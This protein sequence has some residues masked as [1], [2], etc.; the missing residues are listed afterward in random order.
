MTQVDGLTGNSP[1][2]ISHGTG[3]HAVTLVT[4]RIAPMPMLRHA[5]AASC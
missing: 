1:T 4:E 5:G 2:E 3:T